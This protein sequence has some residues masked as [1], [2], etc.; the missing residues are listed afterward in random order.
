VWVSPSLR[1][2][3][4]RLDPFA[5]VEGG[6]SVRGYD[7]EYEREVRGRSRIFRNRGTTE[8][9]GN[10]RR[11]NAPDSGCGET[12]RRDARYGITHRPPER[13]KLALA[14]DQL[15]FSQVSKPVVAL[16][17]NAVPLRSALRQTPP[18]RRLFEKSTF[19]RFMA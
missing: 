15:Q 4:E 10:N 5:L 1:G 11:Q 19:V 7:A 8:G 9:V 18:G 13:R 17:S 14:L 2:L 6:L 16:P 3:F 12:H